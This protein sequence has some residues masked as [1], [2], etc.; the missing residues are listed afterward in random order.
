MKI[1]LTDELTDY[2]GKP[3]TVPDDENTGAK[4][5]VTFFDVFINALNSQLQGEILTSEKKNQIYQISKK[6]YNSN[7][8]NLT[9]EQ[10]A[11]I[12]ERVGKIY[13]PLVYGKVCDRI[14]GV[15]ETKQEATAPA[16]SDTPPAQ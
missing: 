7:E 9:P 13:A 10:L 15:E 3:L 6:I 12:K 14:D 1:K 5:S 4:K 2:E 16:A 11:T 8:P